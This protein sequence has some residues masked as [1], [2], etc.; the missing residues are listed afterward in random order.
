MSYKIKQFKRNQLLVNDYL[1][2]IEEFSNEKNYSQTGYE[3]VIAESLKV[4][5]SS[6]RMP[7]GMK[8]EKGKNYYFTF[9][10][11]DFLNYKVKLVNTDTQAS[12]TV[13]TIQSGYN[14]QEIIFCPNDNYNLIVF[15]LIRNLTNSNNLTREGLSLDTSGSEIFKLYELTNI[16]NT[17]AFLDV[18]YIKKFGLQ[19]PPGL[20]FCM[21]GEEMRLGKSGI[22]EVEDINVDNLAFV[23]KNQSPIPFE[24]A[25]D[26]FILDY[27]Y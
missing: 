22:Y 16:L 17:S 13:K 27:Q 19:G 15:E 6:I 7:E 9:K 20:V 2:I 8:L 18:P 25:V 26:F 5:D 11:W 3:T 14:R 4:K 21:N 12:M 1:K 10:S 24:D 23:L